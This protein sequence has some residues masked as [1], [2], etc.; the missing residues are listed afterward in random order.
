MLDVAQGRVRPEFDLGL[1]EM[2]LAIIVIL[3]VQGVISYVR[4]M[5][6][7]QISEKG[8]ADIRQALYSKII[9]LPIVF[10]E[11]NRA[12]ELN[13]RLTNDIGRIYSTFS[14]ILAEFVRQLIF[15]AGGAIFLLWQTPKLA[16]IMMLTIPVLII[17]AIV[18]GRWIRA[19]SKNR[20][21]VLGDSNTILDEML[22]SIHAVKAFSNE[23]FE[24]NRYRRSNEDVVQVSMK[25]AASK[26]VFAVFVITLLFGALFF[27]IWM[28]MRMIQS[29]EVT[30][31]QLISFV[32][33]TAVV[34]ASIAALS[35]FFTELV[36]AIGASERLLEILDTPSEIEERP[37]TNL[38]AGRLNGDILLEN[39][40]FAYPTR[41]D[42]PVLKGVDMTISSGSK[43]ALVGQSGAGKSTIM[44]L[45]L[46]FHR[47]VSGRILA[48]GQDIQDYDLA[49]YRE[50]FALVPQEVILFGGSIRENILYGKPDATEQEIEAAARQANAWEFISRFPEGLDTVVGE[51]GIKLSG[52]QRQRIAI[53][54]AILR[55]PSV[56][57]LDEATSSLDAESERLVQEALENLMKGR[58]SIIIAHRL[59]TIREVDC[60]YVLE[61]GRIVEQGTHAELSAREDGVYSSL[62]R[63]QFNPIPDQSS[64]GILSPAPR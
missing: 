55:N 51:R 53:A 42:M 17:A 25:F 7:A 52:G 34:G 10:F 28:G 58:T 45:L 37:Q 33:F 46:Q 24:N 5:L 13:S 40:A 47:P 26:A 2:G 38:K 61:G 16:G 8:T 54:R 20:Q 3:L 49:S 43:V 12:G 18:F 44:Q 64:L 60:I 4:V 35:N 29:G 21:K 59:A 6:F 19:L 11:E 22:Q 14:F 57:L 27:V 30:A 41:P 9:S 32:T 63:L 23:M 15:L 62:A 56:L 39:I 36:G 31:G 48:D 50:N 1:V